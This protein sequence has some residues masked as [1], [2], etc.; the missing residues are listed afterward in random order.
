MDQDSVTFGRMPDSGEPVSLQDLYDATHQRLVAHLSAA[1]GDVDGAERAVH[2][3]FVRAAAAG[4]RFW[5][6]PDPEAWLRTTA[7]RVQRSGRRTRAGPTRAGPPTASGPPP[8]PAPVQVAPRAAFELIEAAGLARRRHR[9]TVAG[10]V[11]VCVLALAALATETDGSLTPT[12]ASTSSADQPGPWMTTPRRGTYE[13]MPWPDRPL[14]AVR[15]TVPTP[16]SAWLGPGRTDALNPRVEDDELVLLDGGGSHAGL[17]V[18]SVTAIAGRDCTAKD[19]ADVGPASFVR[20]LAHAPRLEVVDGPRATVRAGRPAVR[21]RLRTLGRQ[22]ACPGLPLF[23]TSR[24]Q[25]AGGP[26]GTTYDAWVVDVD[27]EP[28]LVWA[29]WTRGAPRSD[30]AALHGIVD[31]LVLRDRSGSP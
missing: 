18:A 15:I 16:W 27:G 10:V 8:H 22:L 2:E 4:W 6:V 30:V 26:G 19:V 29:G 21:L 7:A 12:G 20:A 17:L 9:H 13:L 3:A 5:R 25:V 24:G 31:S 11:A 23:T 1:T 28:L 14:A